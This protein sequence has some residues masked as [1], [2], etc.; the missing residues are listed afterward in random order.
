MH[1]KVLVPLDGSEESEGVISLIQDE[2]VPNGELILLR[3]VPPADTRNNPPVGSGW[4]SWVTTALSLEEEEVPDQLDPPTEPYVV[5]GDEI[6]N[7]RHESEWS[8]A[9]NYLQGVAFLLGDPRFQWRCEVVSNRSACQGIVDFATVEN[10][11]AIAMYTHDRRGLVGL[12]KKSIA[13]DVERLTPMDVKVFKPGD[14]KSASRAGYAVGNIAVTKDEVGLT[15]SRPMTLEHIY[16]VEAEAL[17]K[18]IGELSQQRWEILQ[19]I[20]ETDSLYQG[21]DGLQ[22]QLGNERDWIDNQMQARIRDLGAIGD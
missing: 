3:V 7:Q 20:R 6:V 8:R 10:V 4:T 13:R 16:R 22:E 14:I 9:L 21:V 17:E 18:E 15:R 19:Q 12:I 2:V 1:R 5:S 11:D